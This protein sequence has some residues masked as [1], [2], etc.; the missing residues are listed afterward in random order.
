M[1]RMWRKE[2]NANHVATANPRERP[3]SQ[4]K[5]ES[6][7]ENPTVAVVVVERTT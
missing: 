7:V 3:E 1:W 4:E 5:Q 6:P 2:A